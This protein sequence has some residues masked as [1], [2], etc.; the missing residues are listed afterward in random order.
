M[1]YPAQLDVI[2]ALNLAF[3]TWPEASCGPAVQLRNANLNLTRLRSVEGDLRGKSQY[4]ETIM[5]PNLRI[6][7]LDAQGLLVPPARD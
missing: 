7:L 1:M 3:L 6:A 4:H 2:L 5:D